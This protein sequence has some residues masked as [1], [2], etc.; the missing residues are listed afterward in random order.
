MAKAKTNTE[1]NGKK[2]YRITRTI[3]GKRKQFYGTSKSD[4]EYKYRE[5]F[6]EYTRN[7]NARRIASDNSTFHDRANEFIEDVIIPSNRY[8]TSTKNNFSVSYRCHVKGSD[9]DGMRLNDI[10]PSDVQRF[11]NELNVSKQNM[12]LVS[13]FMKVFCKWL[14]RNDYASD[15]ISGVEM[16]KKPDHKR[17]DDIVVW[18]NEEVNRILDGCRKEQ[19]TFRM[20]FMPVLMIYTGMRIGEVLSLRYSDITDGAVSVKRQYT[21]YEIKEPKYDSN[22]AIPLHPDV[23]SALQVHREWHED[24][25]KKRGYETQ[26]VFTTRDG[27][28]QSPPNVRLAL[29]RFYQRIG[30]PYKEPH[31]Y[32]RTFCTMLCKSGVPIQTASELMGHKDISVTAAFYTAISGKEKE[33]AI[34]KLKW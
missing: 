26:Y 10:R 33:N 31:T 24:E 32:R 20:A 15:F 3:D 11:Y 27:N 9:L 12:L 30:V 6:E 21:N 34:N 4:A 23:V 7:R 25:M 29:R 16:P 28:L 14:M 2:Y 5:Y 22:R 13:R 17:S 1:I 18:S 8:A 19:K